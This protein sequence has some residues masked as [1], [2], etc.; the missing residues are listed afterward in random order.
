MLAL[1]TRS[2]ALTLAACLVLG[3]GSGTADAQVVRAYIA[4]AN[5]VID[6]ATNTVVATILAPDMTQIDAE[7]GCWIRW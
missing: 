2:G 3:L 5:V 1:F 7:T 6:V 4:A